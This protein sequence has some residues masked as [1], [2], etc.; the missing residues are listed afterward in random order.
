MVS[1]TPRGL[2]SQTRDRLRDKGS[3]ARQLVLIHTGVT[4]LFSLISSGLNI[5]LDQQISTTSG[6]SG[7]GARSFLQSVQT[8]VQ[9]V[10]TLFS[11]FWSA[12]FLFAALIWAADRKPQTKDLL[13]GFRRFTSVLSYELLLSL[14]SFFLMMGTGY[15]SGLIFSLTPFSD[16]LIELLEPIVASQTMDLSLVDMNAL[17]S[18]YIPFLIFWMLVFIPVITVFLYSLR[19]SIYLILDHPRMGA[20]RAMATSAVAMKGRKFQL[21]RLDLSFWWYY[22]LESL[23]VIVCYLDV[24]LP[25]LG[26]TLPFNSTVGYFVFLALYGILQLVLHLWKKPEVEVSYALA[27]QFITH[28]DHMD[29]PSQN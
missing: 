16:P 7:L 3:N 8:I 1:F 4:V 27:Y 14:I 24:I 29:L 10:S 25:L 23:L 12:G 28:P 5:Y 22:A 20:L 11:P 15:L 21:F 26:I 2:K 18:A 6:L 9:Y 19:L 17:V 13:F